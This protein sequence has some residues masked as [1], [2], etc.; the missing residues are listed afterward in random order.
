MKLL[1]TLRRSLANLPMKRKFLLQTAFVAVGIV[2][3]AV[4]A[5]RM[6]Y[7]DLTAT[8]QAAVQAKVEMALGVIGQYGALAESGALDE[9][10]AKEAALLAMRGM[11]STDGL[12]YFFILDREPR[13]IMH[14]TL[15]GQAL[16]D[17][18]DADGKAIFP[19]FVEAAIAGGGFVDYVWPR[20]GNTDPAPKTSYADL[21]EPWDWVIATGVYVDDT[22]LQALQFTGIMTLAG[23]VLVL[24]N[25]L[26]GWA[27]G[28]SVL[29]AARRA[30]AA[31]R[32]VSNGDL[33]VRMGEHGTDEMGQMLDSI[34]HMQQQLRAVIEAQREM[35]RCHDAGQISY[36]IDDGLFP[37]DYGLMV[38]DANA[39]V[40]QHISVKMRAVEVMHRYAV[41]DLSVDMDRLPGEK[42]VIT[43]AMDTC[44][45]NLAAINAEIHGLVAASAAGDFSRRGNAGAFQHEFHGMVAG[46]NRLMETTDSNLDQLSG[47][48]RT[49]ARGDLTVRMEGDFHGVFARMRDDANA[50][51]DQLTSIVA[52]IQGASGA[53]NSGA[54]EIASGNND[55]SR[56]TEQQAANLEETAASMEELTSTVKQNAD[57]ARQANQLAIGAASVASQGG[58]V[59]GQVVTTM[60]DIQ[61]SSRKIADIISVID[62]IAFQTNILALNAAVEAAR[63]GEQGRGFAVVATE[64]RSLA[65]RSATAAKEI[66]Q[67][68]EDSTGKVAD[69]AKLAEQAG[70]TMGEMVASVQRVTDIM[71][72]ISAASQEQA[73]GIEQ[74]NQ[75]IVQMDETTQQNAALVEEASAAARSMEEQA[76]GLAQAI[77]VFRLENGAGAV[78]AVAAAQTPRRALAG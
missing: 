76:A 28:G 78:Q 39:L 35:A 49:V 62:G 20:P 44:K 67:L 5:A 3:L 73:A 68:I 37:G 22:Q 54:S 47:L 51:V 66:K 41:G 45:R 15:K 13:M 23:G 74:V 61:A 24:V 34:E 7:L 71:A 70:R 56:R 32:G 27:I 65:Q 40:H 77:A 11:R 64:V 69:G 36:R 9:E 14:P 46:L 38:R 31:V 19:A 25:L 59:V 21:Y 29:D 2:G 16:R 58:E 10:T 18:L 48:L 1:D 72:E 52:R 42:A 17:V 4:L 50:T 60:A 30:L 75:T 8:R 43:E 55:L 33:N 6:Q 26:A 57:H 12:D 63:A 53:I